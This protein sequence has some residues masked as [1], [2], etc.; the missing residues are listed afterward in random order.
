[1]KKLLLV[2]I[3]LIS[4]NSY[5]QEEDVVY[6]NIV[7]VSYKTGMNNSET[8][9][10]DWSQTEWNLRIDNF[11]EQKTI[12]VIKDDSDFYVVESYD[13]SIYVDDF[14]I[15]QFSAK[16]RLNEDI[17]IEFMMPQKR[18]NEFFVAIT[19][20]KNEIIMYRIEYTEE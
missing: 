14:I 9:W 2:L 10:S 18:K 12:T 5:A 4:I 7:S 11:K 16:D 3:L 1:M 19:N 15:Y 8:I 6:Y 13:D 17:T 20:K